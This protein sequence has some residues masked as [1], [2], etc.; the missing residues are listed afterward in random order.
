MH[1]TYIKLN[2]IEERFRTPLF[3]QVYQTVINYH[4]GDF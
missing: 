1:S 2:F 4:F 3:D